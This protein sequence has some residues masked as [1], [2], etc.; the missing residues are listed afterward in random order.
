MGFATDVQL[1][2]PSLL[3]D[4]IWGVLALLSA[5]VPAS[6]SVIQNSQAFLLKNQNAD[7]G[8]AWDVGGVSDT[9]D[10]AAAIMALLEFGMTKSDNAIQLAR[11]YL[12]EA[13]NLDGGFPYDPKSP[14][15]TD[16]DANSDSWVMMA[17]QKLGENTEEWTKSPENPVEHLLSLQ[18]EDG[19]FWWVTPGTSEW[20]NKGATADA[21][22]ALSGKSFPIYSLPVFQDQEVMPEQEQLQQEEPQAQL[23]QQEREERTPVSHVSSAPQPIEEEG[24]IVKEQIVEASRQE[25]LREIQTELSRVEE[26]AKEIERHLAALAVEEKQVQETFAQAGEEESESE[27]GVKERE[28]QAFQAKAAAGLSAQAE[29]DMLGFVR[30]NMLLSFAAVFISGFGL[31]WFAHPFFRK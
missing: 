29:A 14:F 17:V 18:D 24:V 19:G 8:W 9:N 27:Q 25:I 1:G 2:D 23:E 20:N 10:T 26:E 16:S 4:D 22:V 7:G 28:V 5:G 21:V 3:N 11:Q 30:N 15:G 31:C 13:Q 12:K 6:D